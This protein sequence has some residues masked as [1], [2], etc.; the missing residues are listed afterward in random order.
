MPYRNSYP[1]SQE[2]CK[3]PRRLHGLCSMHGTRLVR[4]G[5]PTALRQLRFDLPD[6]DKFWLRAVVQDG[7]WGW[8]GSLTSAGYAQFHLR[9]GGRAVGHRW[10]WEQ[11]YG[12]VPEGLELDHLCRNRGCTNPDHLEAVTHRENVQRGLTPI[13]AGN[14]QRA[15][16]ECPKGHPYSPENTGITTIG[17]SVRRYCRTCKRG[18]AR[19]R[20]AR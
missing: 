10:L 20:R 3:K 1:C 8:R 4:N 19:V 14:W 12:P 13:V 16:T 9:G 17:S 18:K 11:L 7:C 6:W 2:G 15:R 5:S